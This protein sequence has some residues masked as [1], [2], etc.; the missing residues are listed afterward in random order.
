MKLYET[1]VV[2]VKSFEVRSSIMSI[3]GTAPDFPGDFV[4]ESI[5]LDD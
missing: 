1:P 2:E 3:G 4:E 5:P